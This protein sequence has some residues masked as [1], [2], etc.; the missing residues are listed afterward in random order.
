MTTP[1]TNGHQSNGH[2]ANGASRYIPRGASGIG[3]HDFVPELGYREYWYPAVED[4]RI[5]R[6]PVALKL[7]GDQI[8]FFRDTANKV[9]ALPDARR[10]PPLGCFP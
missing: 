8:V 6:K 5:S 4:R 7:L 2:Q 10:L 9:A 3:V 1:E